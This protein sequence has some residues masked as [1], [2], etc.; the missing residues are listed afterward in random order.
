VATTGTEVTEL[1]HGRSKPFLV[2][3]GGARILVE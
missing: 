3:R 2:A 1:V